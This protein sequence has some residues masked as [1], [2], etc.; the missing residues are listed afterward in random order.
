MSKT[1]ITYAA[2]YPIF[3]DTT[4]LNNKPLQLLYVDFVMAKRHELLVLELPILNQSAM[5]LLLHLALEHLAPNNLNMRLNEWYDL[6]CKYFVE[7]TEVY[8]LLDQAIEQD[9]ISSYNR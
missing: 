7:Q 5:K 1:K 8:A 6:I 2:Y 3:K 9:I 4:V